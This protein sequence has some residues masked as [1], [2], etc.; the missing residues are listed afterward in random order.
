MEAIQ[1]IFPREICVQA[2]I[3]VDGSKWIGQVGKGE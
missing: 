1:R 3:C 2:L